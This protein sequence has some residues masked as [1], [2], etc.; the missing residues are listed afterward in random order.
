MSSDHTSV[1]RANVVEE[2]LILT[3]MSVLPWLGLILI[4]FISTS[5][6]SML[7]NS[8]IGFKVTRVLEAAMTA[9]APVA[10]H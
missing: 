10:R 7:G 3:W 2:W 5:R 4:R 1:Q 9:E 6:Y 8:G